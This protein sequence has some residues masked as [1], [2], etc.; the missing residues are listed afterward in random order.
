MN[1]SK[2]TARLKAAW[3]TVGGEII[4]FT[5][6]RMS[7]HGIPDRYFMHHTIGGVWVEAKWER[8]QLTASQAL[9]LKK[10]KKFN[11]PCC[12]IRGNSIAVHVDDIVIS[13]EGLTGVTLLRALTDVS[14]RFLGNRG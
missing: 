12:V 3:E 8:R 13:M 5:A 9:M 14:A 11:V 2:F 6:G 1:E 4:P 10:M 7:V